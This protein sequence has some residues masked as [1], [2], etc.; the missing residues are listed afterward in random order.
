MLLD[1]L[2][3]DTQL[4]GD[5]LVAKTP[6]HERED[7]HLARGQVGS[8]SHAAFALTGSLSHSQ[9]RPIGAVGTRSRASESGVI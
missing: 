6:E 5:L 7:L 1:R 9:R 3:R 2:L 4:G 8:R